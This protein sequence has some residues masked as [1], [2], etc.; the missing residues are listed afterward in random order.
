MM[1]KG[2]T[3]PAVK[4]WSSQQVEAIKKTVAQG[5]NDSELTM[6]L[7]LAQ[8]TG[9]DPFAREIWLVQINGRNAILTGRDGYLKIANNNP[10]FKGI[11]SDAIY[12]NDRF[13]RNTS[14][15]VDD[16]VHSY[17][18]KERGKLLGAY[19]RVWR[20]D[21]KV[22]TFFLAPISDYYKSSSSAWKQYPHAMIIKV[23][24]SMALKRAFA[25]SGLCTQEE[26]LPDDRKPANP[27]RV[28]LN[29]IWRDFVSFC[30]GNQEEAKN[31]IISLIGKE[32]SSEWT[33]EDIGNLE[34]YLLQKEI[35]EAETKE[36]V[37]S[38][39]A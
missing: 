14:N 22:P 20:D 11:T 12:S 17:D 27:Q 26:I 36:V 19:A 32:H 6:F 25:I 23:A 7:Y 37:E 9:L 30:G 2:E 29:I 28:R 35:I 4:G 34:D 3:L 16:V 38:E 39:D 5:A 8:K 31:L 33:E 21:R 24:E 10:H 1:T 13:T 15:D 18:I